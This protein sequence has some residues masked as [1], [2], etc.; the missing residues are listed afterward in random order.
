SG[1]RIAFGSISSTR[2][3]CPPG[4]LDSAFLK[5][6]E[7]AA[8][9]FFKGDRLYI[10]LKYHSGTMAFQAKQGKGA[11]TQDTGKTEAVVCKDP[12]PEVCTMEYDPVCGEKK[13]GLM[14][15]YGNGCTACSDQEVIR[16]RYG[17]CP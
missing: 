2:A 17:E 16:Y 3:M 11:Q 15:T 14:K 6:L 9:L 5:D 8:I 12:R 4:S 1:S 13:D 10:D 7:R